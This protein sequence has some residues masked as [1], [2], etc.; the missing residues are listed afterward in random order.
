LAAYIIGIKRTAE[1]ARYRG[2]A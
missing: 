1:A 2:W